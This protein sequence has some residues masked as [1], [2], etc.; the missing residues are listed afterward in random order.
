MST[1]V[2]VAAWGAE[3]RVNCFVRDV[4][5]CLDHAQ[6]TI[7]LTAY[8]THLGNRVL[9][10]SICLKVD[11]SA[12]GV[13]LAVRH[14][15]RLAQLNDL[16]AALPLRK[17]KPA[18]WLKVCHEHLHGADCQ[19]ETCVAIHP[20][21]PAARSLLRNFDN[22]LTSAPVREA[23]RDGR[24]QSTIIS[25]DF[26]AGTVVARV[27]RLVQFSRLLGRGLG[28]LASSLASDDRSNHRSALPRLAHVAHLAPH[29][30]RTWHAG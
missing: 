7:A 26:C 27:A 9:R 30:P 21:L 19:R 25:F 4:R 1:P 17:R 22:A 13:Q 5:A 3:R 20:S 6:R 14:E 18:A 12:V 23:R 28:D 2:N 11:P 8:A 15:M 16:R 29:S 24:G 10:R